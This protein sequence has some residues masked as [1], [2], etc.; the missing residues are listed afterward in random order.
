MGV[1]VGDDCTPLLLFLG[2]VGEYICQ[3]VSYIGG[4]KVRDRFLAERVIVSD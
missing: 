1:E 3:N 2:A 4:R